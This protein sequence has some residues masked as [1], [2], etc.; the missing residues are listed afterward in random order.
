[1]KNAVI[2]GKGVLAHKIYNWLTSNHYNVTYL[3]PVIP[4]QEWDGFSFSGFPNAI[5]SGKYEDI[6]TDKPIDLLIAV[7]YKRI[8]SAEFLSRCDK[9]IN[10]HLSSLPEYRGARGIN[11][12]LK[13]ERGEQGITIHELIPKLDQGP[14]LAQMTFSTYPEFEEVIDVYERA[15]D[16]SFILF[17]H[18]MKY[19][20]K[21]TTVPQDESKATYHSSKD[22]HLLGDRLTF[23]K[24][25]SRALCSDS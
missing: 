12:A 3:V 20:Y 9:A 2:L 10:I 25:K 1:M 23:T 19:L 17:K 5:E 8:I 7:F 15:L 13:Q 6:P 21:I 18:T 11:W 16:Y 22:F 4:H 14:I 24:D